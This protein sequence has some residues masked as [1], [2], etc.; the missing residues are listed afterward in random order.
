[1]EKTFGPNNVKLGPWIKF[2]ADGE[3]NKYAQP[4]M[5][6]RL[7]GGGMVIVE[8]KLTQTLE[9]HAQLKLLYLP[10]LRYIYPSSK[11]WLVNG[12]KNIVI[13]SKWE[14]SSLTDIPTYPVEEILD[15]HWIP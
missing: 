3:V 11:I 12:Y 7:P 13:P 4:D 2:D 8:A 15:Y 9:G 6:V 14:L 5:V 1:M 10:L